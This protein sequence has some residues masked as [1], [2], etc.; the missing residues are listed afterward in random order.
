MHVKLNRHSVLKATSD[1]QIFPWP[2]GSIRICLKSQFGYNCDIRDSMNASVVV[3]HRHL[4][5]FSKDGETSIPS[6]VQTL[7]RDFLR[8]CGMTFGI[9]LQ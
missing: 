3:V 4:E 6:N 1:N 7:E 8:K 2:I 9:N 5:G